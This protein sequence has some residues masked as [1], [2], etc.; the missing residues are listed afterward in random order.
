MMPAI[1]RRIATVRTGAM[2]ARHAS[3]SMARAISDGQIDDV[4]LRSA[5]R[6]TINRSMASWLSSSGRVDVLNTSAGYREGLVNGSTFGAR[7][8]VHGQRCIFRS[9]HS[10]WLFYTNFCEARVRVVRPRIPRDL[11]LSHQA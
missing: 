2:S 11:I 4:S 7:G 3:G 5:S 10:L 1:A 9:A 8:G 6:D